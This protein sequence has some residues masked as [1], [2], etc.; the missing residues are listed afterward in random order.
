M[1]SRHEVTSVIFVSNL[2]PRMNVS[3]VH[4]TRVENWR[5]VYMRLR[6]NGDRVPAMCFDVFYPERDGATIALFGC[7]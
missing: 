7:L 2:L 6:S 4:E 5:Y 3:N 1:E